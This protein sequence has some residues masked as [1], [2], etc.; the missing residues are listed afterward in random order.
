M[1][2]NQESFGKATN[3]AGLHEPVTFRWRVTGYYTPDLLESHLERLTKSTEKYLKDCPWPAKELEYG[4]LRVK[5]MPLCSREER[6]KAPLDKNGRAYFDMTVHESSVSFVQITVQLNPGRIFIPQ[7]LVELHET[8]YDCLFPRR[9]EKYP[10]TKGSG[11][12]SKLPI[13]GF[14]ESNHIFSLVSLCWTDALSTALKGVFIRRGIITHTRAPEHFPASAIVVFMENNL[15]RLK[16]GST[17]S[18]EELSHEC[19]GPIAVQTVV[20]DLLNTYLTSWEAFK[21]TLAATKYEDIAPK[22]IKNIVTNAEI[23]LSC[24]NRLINNIERHVGKPV[25]GSK[26][27]FFL[28]RWIKDC[29][30]TAEPPTVCLDTDITGFD[31]DR[32]KCMLHRKL[33]RYKAALCNM[34]A[35]VRLLDPNTCKRFEQVVDST[36]NT[37]DKADFLHMYAGTRKGMPNLTRGC[38]LDDIKR[39]MEEVED[40]HRKLVD[41]LEVIKQE[42]GR[43]IYLN[44]R[45]SSFHSA[46][47]KEKCYDSDSTD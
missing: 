19:N 37:P 47:L 18:A 29:F 39:F 35:T 40:T 21:H 34:I 8:L 15:L 9:G 25:P 23:M 16:A 4:H 44:S 1:I 43:S 33:R 11:F 6:N 31:V 12:C 32:S 14:E 42:I 10:V 46:E 5:S 20:H 38:L 28:K 27:R 26:S 7:N 22:M 41:D 17:E 30:R 45:G 13:G 36:A 3:S 24:L 2:A